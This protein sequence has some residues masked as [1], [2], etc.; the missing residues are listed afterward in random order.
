MTDNTQMTPEKELE[1]LKSEKEQK[2][3]ISK[4]LDRLWEMFPDVTL[5]DTPDE[6]WSLVENGETLLGAYCIMLAKSNLEKEKPQQKDLE[7]ASKTLPA[8]KST[9]QAKEYFTR[10]QVNKMTRDQVRKNYD[11]IVSSMKHWN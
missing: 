3:K 11:K 4:E 1:I 8:V 5:E 7:N 2:D 10:E 6:L 9:S